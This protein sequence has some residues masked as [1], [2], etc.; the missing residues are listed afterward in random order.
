MRQALPPLVARL[1]LEGGDLDIGAELLLCAPAPRC[2]PA[3][4][5]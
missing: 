1:L 5:P 2:P 4:A 3:F